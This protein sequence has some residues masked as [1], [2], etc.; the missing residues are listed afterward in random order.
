MDLSSAMSAAESIAKF[1]KKSESNRPKP[2]AKGD[3]RRDEEDRRSNQGEDESRGRTN[4]P[5][6][7]SKK[8]WKG[9]I[10]EVKFKCY[11]FGG[12][13]LK[14]D[15]PNRVNREQVNAIQTEEDIEDEESGRLGVIVSYKAIKPRVDQPYTLR[16]WWDQLTCRVS[17]QAAANC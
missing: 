7:E 2:R 4:K 17:T 15:C 6:E 13:H 12:N 16:H 11:S 1:E 10:V 5:R 14:R 3:G 9:R 8:T